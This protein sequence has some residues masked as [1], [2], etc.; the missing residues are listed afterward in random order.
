M[1][2]NREKS[3]QP[4]CIFTIDV[5]DWYHI[6]DLPST[7]G[8]EQ[9]SSLTPRVEQNFRRLLE[10]LDEYQIKATCFF[11]GW[12]AER[13][14]Q[15]VAEA[16][17]AGHEIGSHG[18]AHELAAHLGRDRFLEDA[19][20]AKGIIEDA[21]NCR[22]SGFRGTGFSITEETPWF[23]EAVAEAGYTYDTSVFPAR[24]A[25]GGM[26]NAKRFPF[27]L[28]TAHGRLI[29]FPISVADVL[30]RPVCF[31]GGG[32]FRLFPYA[33]IRR[34]TR[35]LLSEN[36]PVV[37]YLH[38]REIDPAQPRLPMSPRRR[39]QTYVNIAGTEK[40]LRLLLSEFKFVTMSQYL[41]SA[42]FKREPIL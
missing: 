34:M 18:F 26:P 35:K 17:A 25:H 5:E 24:R 19:R 22:V 21:A 14:P 4:T 42:A 23:L 31:F 38:P 15:L 27:T 10:L 7:P 40:K 11:L 41:H 6:L 30:G 36:K 29:E 20:R 28:V 1:L 13:W 37:F 33:L 3:A 39:F 12:I 8:V 2:T 32:Y 9:W 16:Q